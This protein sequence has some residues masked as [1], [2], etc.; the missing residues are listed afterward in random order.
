LGEDDTPWDKVFAA[1][2]GG[3]TEFFI[4]EQERYPQPNTPLQC[5]ERCLKTCGSRDMACHVRREM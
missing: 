1:L 5:V 2:E 3:T 4:V